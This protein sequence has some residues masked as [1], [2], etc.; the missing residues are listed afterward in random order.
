MNSTR[1]EAAKR[2]SG[3]VELLGGPENFAKY[4]NT[5]SNEE[6]IDLIY[7]SPMIQALFKKQNEIFKTSNESFKNDKESK[8][9]RGLGNDA[10]KKLRDQKALEL[11]T[12]AV[13]YANQVSHNK[14]NQDCNYCYSHKGCTKLFITKNCNTFN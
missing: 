10:F 7:H 12:Q 11:Y 3:I 1:Q 5:K 4:E 8:R 9:L 6:R 14:K 2:R 13:V